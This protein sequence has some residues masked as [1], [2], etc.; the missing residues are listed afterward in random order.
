LGK[1]S[2]SIGVGASND[3]SNGPSSYGGSFYDGHLVFPNLPSLFVNLVVF[4]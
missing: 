4:L 3:L 2:E 1:I